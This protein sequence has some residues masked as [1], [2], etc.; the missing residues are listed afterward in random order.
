LVSQRDQ[1]ATRAAQARE[2]AGV[3]ATCG[4]SLFGMVPLDIYDRRCCSADCVV[5]LRRRLLA[6]AAA[7]RMGGTA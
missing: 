4:V 3:C 1:E 5:K 7:K 6:D 2:A